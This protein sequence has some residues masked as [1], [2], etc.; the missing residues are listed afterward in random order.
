MVSTFDGCGSDAGF[1]LLAM[2]NKVTSLRTA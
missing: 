2:F 1:S